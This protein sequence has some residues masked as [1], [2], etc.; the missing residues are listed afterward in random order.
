MQARPQAPQLFW[1]NCVLTQVP[2]H[3][4]V[5]PKHIAEHMPNWQAWPVGQVRPQAPQFVGS[6]NV[7]TQRPLQSVSP[8]PQKQRPPKQL[9][10]HVM[11]QPPQFAVSF[12]V[13]THAPEHS[14]SP[15]VQPATHAPAVHTWPVAQAVSTQTPPTQFSWPLPWTLQIGA[16]PTVHA[17]PVAT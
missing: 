11:P 7:F 14:V 4:V 13:F 9:P 5:P 15:M 1:S 16:T 8:P 3:S 12:C 2:E 17:E 6:V 10:G